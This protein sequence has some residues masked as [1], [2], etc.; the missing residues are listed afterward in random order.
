[1]TSRRDS[2]SSLASGSNA[3]LATSNVSRVTQNVQSQTI[4]LWEVT[5]YCVLIDRAVGVLSDLRG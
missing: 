5:R 3:T 1:M 4:M 2:Q